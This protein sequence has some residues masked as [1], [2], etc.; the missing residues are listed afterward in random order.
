MQQEEIKQLFDSQ[1]PGYDRQWARM[2]PIRD[3]LHFLLEPVFAELPEDARV[4]C[5]GAGTGAEMAHFARVFPRWKFTAVDPSGAM[6]EVCRTRAAAEGFESRCTFHEGY[7][8]SLPVDEKH[9]GATCFLVSQ[10]ILVPEARTGLFR[11]I[12]ARL[13]PAGILASSDLA[14]DR[15]SRDY[16]QL[17]VPWFR[18]MSQSGI[19]PEALERMRNAYAK[20]VSILPAVRVAAHIAAGGFDPPVQFYQAGLIHG[21]FSRLKTR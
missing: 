9:H 21:W 1:A 14:S 6:L 15:E 18:M 8:D 17:L 19:Q 16:E 10:F 12:A 5:V 11:D 3:C 2:S 20:D 13:L 4:L 7:V